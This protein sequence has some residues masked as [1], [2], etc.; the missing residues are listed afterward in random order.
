MTSNHKTI[1]VMNDGT[2]E[3]SARADSG[4]SI[5]ATT[6]ADITGSRIGRARL[7]ATMNRMTNIPMVADCAAVR[8]ICATS[9]TGLGSLT[10]SAK[11]ASRSG[12]VVGSRR[13]PVLVLTASMALITGEV[14]FG[15]PAP[16]PPIDSE[17]PADGLSACF[18][19]T[20]TKIGYL[21]GDNASPN[22]PA[23]TGLCGV[24]CG[25]HDGNGTGSHPVE[26]R[27]RPSAGEYLRQPHAELLCPRGYKARRREDKVQ[28]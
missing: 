25:R 15:C 22:N 26:D 12:S 13:W 27:L 16:L 23:N 6:K 3:R 18:T 10:E 19:R 8:Q 24:H 14:P 1:A 11:R 17:G 9:A 20:K 2:R 28:G 7:K 21:G 4:P 5:M